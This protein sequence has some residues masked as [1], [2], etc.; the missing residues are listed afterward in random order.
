MRVN[1]GGVIPLSTVD[2]AGRASTVVFLRGCP[3][4]C[5]FCHNR[6]LQTGESQADFSSLA[7]D[8][9]HTVNGSIVHQSPG[10]IT[11]TEAAEQVAAKPLVSAL[12]LSG[13]EP[14]MQPKA[15]E[16]LLQLADNLD[17]H[18]GL[19]TCGY[20]PQRLKQL[21]EKS[22]VDRLFLDIKSSLREPDYSRATGRDDV[23]PR[24]KESLELAMS[25]SV[26]LE[27]RITIFP[28]TFGHLE[29]R[30]IAEQLRDLKSTYSD[31]CLQGVTL[32]QG[33]PRKRE[34]KPLSLEELNRM[35]SSI[36]DLVTVTVKGQPATKIGK[37][38]Y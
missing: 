14:L 32:Q 24:V 33:R 5:P 12:V 28:Q 8:L 22:L 16:A 13:G 34:F 29:V 3:L 10:Q 30:S 7:R 35:A 26:A 15:A 9:R 2:W 6:E 4:R 1:L 18:A 25:S 19:E 27:I 36:A 37:S 38:D 21:L 23:L 11:I 20:Y 17:L 31:H